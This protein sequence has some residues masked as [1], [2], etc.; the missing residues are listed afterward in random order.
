M[1][2]K[3][4]MEGYVRSRDRKTIRENVVEEGII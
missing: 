1:A 3:G 2:M 4:N